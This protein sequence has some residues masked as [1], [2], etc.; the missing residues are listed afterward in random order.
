[1][2]KEQMA[3]K[4]M[5]LAADMSKRYYGK[6]LLLT[7]SGGKDSE[8]CLEIAQRAGIDCEVVCSWTTADAPE[9]CYHI[10][11]RF[12]ELED[13]G[14]K[15]TIRYPTYKGA[16]ISMWSLIP[17][18]LRPPTRISRYCCDVLKE[19]AGRGR[20]IATGIRRAESRNRQGREGA[21]T[22]G[23]KRVGTSF[24]AVADLYEGNDGREMV[25]HDREFLESC[26]VKGSTAFHPIIDWSDTDVWEYIESER[27]DVN[28]IYRE[29]G[30]FRVGCVGCPMGCA[31]KKELQIWPKFKAMYISA[32]DRML[33]VRKT[34]GK[35]DST[36]KW[37]DAN[38]VFDWWMESDDIPGQMSLF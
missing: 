21:E 17:I 30:L 11:R 37:K 29:Y 2:D 8:V 25:E 6:P 7:Y 38:A 10:R 32:F 33:K 23:A 5:K 35:D 26:K 16:P 24:D 13:C 18:K 27:L 34:R 22:V 9:T 4:R 15:C 28:P 12:K 3:I 20:A 19:Q 14:V 31:R 36:G 1:M